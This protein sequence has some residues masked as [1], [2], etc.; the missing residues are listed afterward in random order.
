MSQGLHWCE[1]W[2]SIRAPVA[3]SINMKKL[4]PRDFHEDTQNS[5]F[6]DFG[7]VVDSFP[8]GRRRFQSIIRMAHRELPCH[9]LQGPGMMIN[10]TA[11][12][13]PR[14]TQP[15]PSTQDTLPSLPHG[16]FLM[17][18]IIMITPPRSISQLHS[19]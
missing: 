16:H 7:L 9:V 5:S 17:S 13:L 3:R 4:A 6:V 12:N 18:H 10:T 8:L 2:A 14:P 11:K 19:I 1:S 15:P